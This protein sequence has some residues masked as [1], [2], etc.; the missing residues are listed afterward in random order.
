MLAQHSRPVVI[1]IP[2]LW[3]DFMLQAK[4]TVVLREQLYCSTQC[5]CL[6]LQMLF[7]HAKQVYLAAACVSLGIAS[8]KSY[9]SV[10]NVVSFP[11]FQSP[12][13]LIGETSHNAKSPPQRENFEALVNQTPL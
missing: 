6:T 1:T 13:P 3:S 5:V 4:S 11:V 7:D 10:S 9:R 2:F 8:T 12:S